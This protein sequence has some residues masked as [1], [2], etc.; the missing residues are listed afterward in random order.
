MRAKLVDCAVSIGLLK[1][2]GQAYDRGTMTICT[3]TLR[4]LFAYLAKSLMLTACVLMSLLVARAK[5]PSPV[6]YHRSIITDH[7]L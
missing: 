2:H 6:A 1:D 7:R 3:K 5:L 4:V